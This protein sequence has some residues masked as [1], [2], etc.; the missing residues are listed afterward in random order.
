MTGLNNTIRQ[1]N[2]SMFILENTGKAFGAEWQTLKAQKDAA[3]AE[4]QRLADEAR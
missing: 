3:I 1:C 2:Q 4:C